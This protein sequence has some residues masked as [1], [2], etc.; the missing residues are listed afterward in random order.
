MSQFYFHSIAKFQLGDLK[1]SDTICDDISRFEHGGYGQSPL[2]GSTY[3]G[4]G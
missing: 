2:S 1:A 4:A 3:Q